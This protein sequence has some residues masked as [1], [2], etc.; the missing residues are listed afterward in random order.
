LQIYTGE[1][2]AIQASSE[3]CFVVPSN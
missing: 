2:P 3:S 1:P